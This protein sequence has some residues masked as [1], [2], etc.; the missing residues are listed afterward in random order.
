[1]FTIGR[2][3]RLPRACCPPA[4]PCSSSRPARS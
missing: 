4:S 3:G 2:G 1:V